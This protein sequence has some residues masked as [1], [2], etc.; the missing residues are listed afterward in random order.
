MSSSTIFSGSKVKALKDVIS[1]NGNEDLIHASTDPTTNNYDA[2]AGSIIFYSGQIYRKKSSGNNTD[3]ELIGT[4]ASSN[5]TVTTK[6]TTAT[7][8]ALERGVILASTSGG[9]YTITLPTAVGNSGLFYHFKKTTN[10]LT[11]LTIDA[12]GSETIDGSL[13][14]VMDVRHEELSIVSDGSNWNILHIYIPF[15]GV[16]Y[17]TNAGSTLTSGTDTYIDFEDLVY[18]P[19]SLVS[20]AGG[21]NK[22]VPSTGWRFTA[23]KAGKYRVTGSVEL[24]N[25]DFDIGERMYIRPVNETSG[26]SYVISQFVASASSTTAERQVSGSV[27]MTC[28]KNDVVDIQVNQNT[29]SSES[30]VASAETNFI[31]I[32][33]IGV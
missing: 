11:Q 2:S 16:G 31:M 8:T 26:Q 6:T 23:P 5:L 32:D 19:Y 25:G 13:T 3:V 4:G 20:G 30:L 29:G 15:I 22:T 14:R 18:D 24:Q 12:N 33:F 27:V 7:L 28:A 10:D 1:I 21:G 17:T 9:A